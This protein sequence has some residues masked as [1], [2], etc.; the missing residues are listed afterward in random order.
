[1]NS[2]TPGFGR[3]GRT[4]MRRVEGRGEV[5]H[6]AIVRQSDNCPARNGRWMIVR[7]V[8]VARCEC[9]IHHGVWAL[10]DVYAGRLYRATRP[11]QNKD[12]REVRRRLYARGRGPDRS[13]TSASSSQCR[14]V[15]R[16]LRYPRLRLGGEAV[17]T[18]SARQ[19][20]GSGLYMISTSRPF[21]NC[22][23]G[24]EIELSMMYY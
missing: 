14:G 7:K 21:E 8:L 19:W 22:A 10:A 1:M 5:E 23:H 24:S 16:G 3:A 15:F 18:V 2:D 13:G 4:A 9:F 20:A 11:H 12:E 17:E 6:P